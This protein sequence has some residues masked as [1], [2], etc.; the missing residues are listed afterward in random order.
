MDRLLLT[1]KE[2]RMILNI[3][4]SI[5]CPYRGPCRIGAV[6]TKDIGGRA[7]SF[8]PLVLMDDSGDVVFVPVGKVKNVGMRRL[9]KKS[10]IPK[11]LR[12]LSQEVDTVTGPNTRMTWKRR[13]TDNFNL[14][15]SGS[16][17]DL[18]TIIGS[19][20]ELNETTPLS[21]RDREVLDKARK[22]LIC[23]IA[24]VMHEA[25]SAAEQRVNKALDAVKRRSTT[26]QEYRKLS[27]PALGER[28]R[29]TR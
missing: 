28:V 2:N 14:F 25:K 16:A 9:V 27:R 20:T 6:V 19:L 17:L 23:E 24:E 13:A 12:R 8:Y 22:N 10:E 18:A 5:V 7:E 1:G 3:G 4:K 21:P 26:S 15:A 29:S 11:L